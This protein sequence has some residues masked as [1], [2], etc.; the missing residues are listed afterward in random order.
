MRVLCEV[1]QIEMEGDYATVEGVCVRCSRCEHSVEVFG[2]SDRSIRRGLVMLREECPEEE[3]NF[4][5]TDED[6]SS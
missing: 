2:T 1:G 3:S 6:A 5:V 4:Y